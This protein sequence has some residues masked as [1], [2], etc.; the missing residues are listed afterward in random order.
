MFDKTGESGDPCGIPSSLGIF[1]PSIMI[2]AS[3]YLRISFKTLRSVT[4]R[5][6][7]A[8]RTSC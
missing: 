4:L 3:R 8:I 6:T 5:A 2:P 7:R 1:T